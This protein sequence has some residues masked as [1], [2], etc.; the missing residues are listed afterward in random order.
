MFLFV[1]LCQGI[2]FCLTKGR[3]ETQRSG[4]VGVGVGVR[5]VGVWGWWLVVGLRVLFGRR[6]LALN[7]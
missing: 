5:C 3:E 7:L 1:E 4:S 2:Y 6:F